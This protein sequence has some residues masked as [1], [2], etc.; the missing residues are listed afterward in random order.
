ME[1]NV[2]PVGGATAFMRRAVP[3]RFLQE[4]QVGPV[5][6]MRIGMAGFS[7]PSVAARPLPLLGQQ[8]APAATPQAP[9]TPRQCP[10]PIALPDGTVIEP[11]D[12]IKLKDLCQVLPTLMEAMSAAAQAKA[13]GGM[14]AP[15]QTVPVAGGIPG[16][17][18]VPT[19]GMFPGFGAPTGPFGSGG[20]AMFGS[21]GGGGAGPGPQGLPGPAGPAGPAG[22]GSTIGFVMKTDGDFI[23]AAGPF[24]PVPGASLAFT[25]S[26]D[27]PVLFL[28][29]ANLLTL[30]LG[31]T[32]QNGQVGLRIDGTEYGL[33]TR[34]I[35]TFA[36]G[37]GEFSV[38]H[39]QMFT[40]NLAAGSHT[41]E[42]L[43]RGCPSAEI[44]GGLDLPTAVSANPNDPLVLMA[45]HS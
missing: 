43:L 15:G 13:R 17:G 31:A 34:V 35:H 41:V 7:S 21:G 27:G 18:A 20:G 30:A 6:Q 4:P 16:V 8:Q 1:E 29:Q 25:T 45:L 42:V 36:G 37:V 26:Q 5:V 40:L 3:L 14:P 33:A 22:P 10:G 39:T 28:V 2:N 44:V 32:S 9:A 19:P 23:A 24:I 38:G 12:Y 11:D